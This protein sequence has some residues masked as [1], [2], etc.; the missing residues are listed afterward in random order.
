M[1]DRFL[2][3]LSRW[4]VPGMSVWC[5]HVVLV[6]ELIKKIQLPGFSLEFRF[7]KPWVGGRI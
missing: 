6:E 3:E 5:S 7:R 2:M 4:L 1:K